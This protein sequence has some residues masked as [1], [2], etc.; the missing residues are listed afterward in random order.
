MKSIKQIADELGVTKQAIYQRIKRKPL[1]TLLSMFTLA[2]NGLVNIEVENIIKSAFSKQKSVDSFTETFTQSKHNDDIVNKKVFTDSQPVNEPVNVY[3]ENNEIVN[4]N[5][6]YAV[7]IDNIVNKPVN[8]ESTFTQSK[9]E[10]KHNLFTL[11]DLKKL[12]V[13]VN[14]KSE[15]RDGK[16]TKIPYNPRT[17]SFFKSSRVNKLCLLSCLL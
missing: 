12:P 9:H 5:V 16:A 11:E 6:Y 8:I 10:S 13:W 4:E 3:S 1:S 2:V 7:N 15:E 14:W 17:G